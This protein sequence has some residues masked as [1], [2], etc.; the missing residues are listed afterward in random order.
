MVERFPDVARS[1]P[2][3]PEQPRNTP[4]RLVTFSSPKERVIHTLRS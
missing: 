3:R 4:V 1:N 2:Q